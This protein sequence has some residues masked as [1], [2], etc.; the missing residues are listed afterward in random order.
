MKSVMDCDG[1]FEILT[2][3]PFPS[4]DEHDAAVEAHLCVC[5]DCR[6]LA[7]ALRPAVG[8]LH[9]S[10]AGEDSLPAYAGRLAELRPGLGLRTPRLLHTGPLIAAMTAACLV[11]WV[12]RAAS[13]TS[14]PLPPDARRPVA[15]S[16][17]GP[18]TL[19]GL[20]LPFA[21]FGT[22][23]RAGETF[24]I[25]V[26]PPTSGREVTLQYLCCSSCHR[27]EGTGPASDRAVQVVSNACSSCHRRSGK[28]GVS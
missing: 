5:H 14:G 27:P 7:D 26:A 17:V 4:G 19:A 15:Q 21:C 8:L 1:V 13:H 10:L 6:R 20:N 2:R 3:A 9:E 11:L 23:R 18:S 12:L 22:N 16:A 24:T 28:P 25:E